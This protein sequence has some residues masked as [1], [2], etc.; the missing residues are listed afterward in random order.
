MGK[1]VFLSIALAG[2]AACH[3][4][5]RTVTVASCDR[6]TGA[7]TLAIS[8]AEAGDGAKAL[9]AAWSPSDVGNAVTNERETVYVGVVAAAETEKSFTIPAAW[10]GKAGFVRFYLM[11]DMPP[12]DARLASLRTPS[13]GPYIDTGFAERQQRHPRDARLRK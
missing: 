3:A 12:Y 13:A 4:A 7:T 6:S 11:A 5:A 8:A 2:L 1:Q 9:V 10:R